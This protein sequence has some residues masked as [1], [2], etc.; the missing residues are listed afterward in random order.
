MFF[1]FLGSTPISP[2][3]LSLST[4]QFNSSNN[5]VNASTSEISGTLYIST[6]S[7]ERTIEGIN[8]TVAFFAPEIVTVPLSLCPPSI[9][10]TSSAIFIQSFR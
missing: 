2:T 5:V 9:A 1:I 6:G 7:S 3:D 4:T 8:A 10:I